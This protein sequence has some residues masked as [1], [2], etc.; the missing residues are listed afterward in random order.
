MKEMPLILICDKDDYERTP[1]GGWGR[2]VRKVSESFFLD[3]ELA[4]LRHCFVLHEG[5]RGGC[6]FKNIFLGASIYE[7]K[8]SPGCTNLSN[9]SYRS[10]CDIHQFT[11]T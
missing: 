3:Y 1:E 7:A 2:G 8:L 11:L 9:R 6:Y 4:P 10:A 5:C